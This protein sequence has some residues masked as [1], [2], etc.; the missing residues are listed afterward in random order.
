MADRPQFEAYCGFGEVPTD[1]CK[2]A[3]VDH[4]TGKEVCR[5]WDE[6][7]ARCIA[8]LLNANVITKEGQSD[9]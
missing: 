9:G 3:V 8:D 5:V 4:G 6:Y 2:F 1:C 7:M